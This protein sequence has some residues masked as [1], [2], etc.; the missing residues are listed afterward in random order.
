MQIDFN[1]TAINFAFP[2]TFFFIDTQKPFKI[3]PLMFNVMEMELGK[4]FFTNEPNDVMNKLMFLIEASEGKITRLIGHE[5]SIIFF[6][7]YLL[8]P[9]VVLACLLSMNYD[10]QGLINNF[11]RR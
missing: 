6:F 7:I 5:K 11:N 1:P 9:F 4:S 10:I 8:Y 2:L 3:A